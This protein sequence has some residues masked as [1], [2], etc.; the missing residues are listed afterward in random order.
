[1]K[2]LKTTRALVASLALIA[3]SPAWTQA[4]ET[5]ETTTM[6]PEGS[7]Q[8][9]ENAEQSGE[10][11]EEPVEEVEEE[12]PVETEE[13]APVEEAPAE[14]T[15]V[16]EEQVEEAPAEEEAAPTEEAPAEGAPAE[17]AAPAEDATET[18]AET[19]E[20]NEEAPV[21]E[22]PVTETPV[23]ETPETDAPA[24][25]VQEEQS[26]D[27]PVEEA[28]TET[29][30]EA[31]ATEE[32]PAE[33]GDESAAEETQ[34]EAEAETTDDAPAEA[35][36]ETSAET[37][38]PEAVE[39]ETADPEAEAA[40]ESDDSAE[41]ETIVV[42]DAP[43]TAAAATEGESEPVEVIEDTV[44][45]ETARSSD[46]D[47][48]T[49][50][51]EAATAA[52]PAAS[53]S[54]DDSGLSN[55]EKAAIVGLGA[56]AVGALLNNGSEVVSNSGDRVVVR[57]GNQFRVLKD[58]DALLRRPG[59]ETRTARY[60]DGS[61]RTIMNRPDGSQIT[62]IRDAQ[63]R[64]LRRTRI[65]PDGTELLLFDDTLASDPVDLT[66]LRRSSRDIEVIDF[67]KTDQQALRDA[68]EAEASA[69][70][71]R[72]YSLRQVRN[73]REVRELMPRVDL[74][75]VNFETGSAAIAPE[76]ARA[77]RAL[78]VLLEEYIR[79]NPREVFLIEG[80]TDAVG[81]TSSNL[82]LSDRRAESVALALTEYFDV[83]PEN[84][85]VQGYGEDFLKVQTDGPSEENRRATV[86]RITP[87]LRSAAA[88]N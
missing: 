79:E 48:E 67:S 74:D 8:P 60:S 4:A 63:G 47:F 57:D 44:T 62:T 36:A 73:I 80:H 51:G 30:A 32:A 28:P 66:N 24:E 69:D 26:A 59:I 45:E 20:A 39:S 43:E 40:P 10:V 41:E 22:A 31:E 21:E 27:A 38:E 86:R 83:P 75:A 2:S 46:E 1:M 84:L 16:E 25:E 88:A 78:G 12:A 7:D 11:T 42:D 3:P 77:L 35:D 15:A 65:E 56:L 81:S 34:P 50:V 64:V 14:E 53:A 72:R 13:A 55:L 33:S 52:A 5:E 87:L 76:E 6:C 37:D 85:I 70:V 9:C 18:E 17:E 58:D 61:T 29:E 49:S 71:D 19:G 82:A 23:E 68:L 54:S